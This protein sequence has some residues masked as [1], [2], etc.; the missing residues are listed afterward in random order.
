MNSPS[1]SGFN[2]DVTVEFVGAVIPAEIDMVEWNQHLFIK[3]G[4]ILISQQ[5]HNNKTFNYSLFNNLNEF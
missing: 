3:G 4:K 5:Q 1:G 2:L